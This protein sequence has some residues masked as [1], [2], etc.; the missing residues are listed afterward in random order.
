MEV[1]MVQKLKGVPET[2]LIPLWAKATETKRSKPII[3][4]E[5]ALEIMEQ[6]DYDFS[7]F[8]D[9]EPTQVSIA[10]RTELLDMAT[11]AF[12]DRY[13]SASIIN[14][15]CGLDTR[16]LRVNNYEIQW[17]DLDFPETIQ[18]RE[19]FFSETD[20]YKMIARN[21]FDYAWIDIIK[22]NEQF[23]II[24]EGLFMYFT[25]EEVKN[26]MN[27]LLD[28]FPGAEM[29]LETIPDSLAKKSQKQDLIKKQY[30]IEAHF[31]WGI[32]NGKAIEEF[33]SRIEFL[34]EWHYFDYH[35][36]RWK[37]IRWLSLIPTFKNRF[38]N[39]IVHLKFN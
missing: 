12:I 35:R 29:L 26:L 33:D 7:K 28:A 34:E 27:K 30:D 31:Q 19:E 16:F 9:Q 18:I 22:P 10:I 11:K 24:A 21:V 5:K 14:L 2:L 36:D 25:E 3:K 38:G 13:P 4:D 15:G 37:I 17:Y 23:L 39:R 32:K 20:K 6:I 8:D 1:K